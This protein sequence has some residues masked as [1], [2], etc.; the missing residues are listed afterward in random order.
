[1]KRIFRYILAIALVAFAAACITIGVFGSVKLDYCKSIITYKDGFA[2]IQEGSIFDTIFYTDSDGNLL[3]QIKIPYTNYLT[4]HIHNYETLFTDDEGNVY[5]YDRVYKKNGVVTREISSCRFDL[6]ILQKKWQIETPEGC[7]FVEEQIPTIENDTLYLVWRDE[8]TKDILTYAYDVNG[9]AECIETLAVGTS[10]DETVYTPYGLAVVT[11]SKGV[12]WHGERVYKAGSS[13]NLISGIV[14]ENGAIRFY[15]QKL[16]KL[17]TIDIDGNETETSMYQQQDFAEFQSVRLT[18]KNILT[19]CYENGTSLNGILVK[20]EEVQIYSKV[21]GKFQWK[22]FGFFGIVFLFLLLARWGIRRLGALFHGKQLIKKKK[23]RYASLASNI[24]LLTA[25][26]VLLLTVVSGYRIFKN[27]KSSYE[28]W[29]EEDCQSANQYMIGQTS[30]GY[31]DYEDGQYCFTDYIIEMLDDAADLYNDNMINAGQNENYNFVILYYEDGALYAVYSDEVKTVTDATDV[32]SHGAAAKLIEYIE[33]GEYSRFQEK[34]ST[35]R[36]QYTSTPFLMQCLDLGKNILGVVVAI[37]D[38][39][40]E[41]LYYLSVVPKV[42]MVICFM[43]LLLWILINIMLSAFLRRVKKL[44]NNLKTYADTRDYRNFE[45]KGE[46]EIG[47]TAHA[48]R[49]M[50]GGIEVHRNSIT[51]S[52]S[53]Y[54]KLL[55]SGIMHLMGKER[56]TQIAVGEY[57]EVKGH[58]LLFTFQHREQVTREEQLYQAAEY[59][60]KCQG[61][62]IHFN[63]NALYMAV[64]TQSDIAELIQHFHKETGMEYGIE[65][66]AATGSFTAGSAGS[67]SNAYLTATGAVF[68]QL[69]TQENMEKGELNG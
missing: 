23:V 50:A 34:W 56:I 43:S 42:L 46:D 14:Y 15:N 30:G 1:M 3:G 25:L 63:R 67:G 19:A 64:S 45:V 31:L 54:Q 53:K 13:A 7:S 10:I 4:S 24:R 55:P 61:T 6:G 48:L 36:L 39:Y 69:L 33:T 40:Q 2:A 51:E 49:A 16:K 32:I 62:V 5:V 59:G 37:N 28:F 44:G 8:D 12:Y 58:I 29:I 18:P 47:Q 66:R 65:V 11:G 38:G 52:N 22:I 27:L 20:D 17:I 35:G 60:K 26:V 21:T 57:C 41:K 9:E 68:R